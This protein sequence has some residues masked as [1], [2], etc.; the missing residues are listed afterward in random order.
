MLSAC[1]TRLLENYPVANTIVAST[2]AVISSAFEIT[3]I[4]Y[5]SQV[6]KE[7]V[8]LISIIAI[9]CLGLKKSIE[10]QSASGT[11]LFTA[12][13]LLGGGALVMTHDYHFICAQLRL[14]RIE[15]EHKQRL[16]DELQ[17]S[18]RQMRALTETIGPLQ[19]RLRIFEETHADVARVVEMLV[20]TRFEN[21]RLKAELADRVAELQ[22]A[23]QTLTT[24]AHRIDTSS[25]ESESTLH[26]LH[27]VSINI[28]SMTR[29]LGEPAQER[30]FFEM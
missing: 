4:I 6:T 24:A 29:R 14:A 9:G 17:E 20:Q 30:A 15:L 11:I 1:A 3:S 25:L 13:I 10:I 16:L 19:E 23:A 12:V 27:E 28:L 18:T 7:R 21:E 2:E 8:V 26:N 5:E 22:E